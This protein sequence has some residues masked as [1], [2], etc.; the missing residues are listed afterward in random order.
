MTFI[1]RALPAIII[2][3]L[4]VVV[5]VGAS[6]P[7]WRTAVRVTL[8]A[9]GTDVPDGFLSALS[10]PSAGDCAAA[11]SFDATDAVQGLL[12]SEVGGVWHATAATVPTN[13]ASNPATT[14]YGISCGSAG[15]CGAVG[16]YA[17][18]SG[19]VEALA[20]SEVGGVW[21]RGVEITLPA[22][23]S[24]AQ[25]AE[26]HSVACVAPG[27]CSALGSYHAAST[28]HV[29]GF[30]V[31]EVGGVW[32]RATMISLPTDANANPFV[33]ADQVACGAA[34]DCSAV[35]TYV[36]TGGVS[37]ALVA[38][39][40]GGAWRPA[41][42]EALPANANAFANA[43]FSSITCTRPGDCTAL[44]TYDDS[45]GDVEAM[46]ASEVVGAWGRAREITL[47]T[48]A[49]ANSRVLLYGFDGVACATPTS[50][51]AGGQYVDGSGDYQGFVVNETDGVWGVATRLALPS[52]ATEVGKNGGVVSLTCPSAGDCSAGAAYL[53]ASGDY[54]A[55]VASEVG[56]VWQTAQ[57]ITL[58]AGAASVGVDGGIYGVICHA[59]DCTALGSYL[60]NATTYEGFTVTAP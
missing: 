28:S 16:S 27:T 44:G 31:N 9:G 40:V 21:R 59:G 46:V 42:A 45:S 43:Q 14:L 57:K 51:S 19:N 24:A 29:E 1:R 49:A 15:N 41:V 23:A 12:L 13:A 54:Q 8:P 22:G 32:R 56:G 35:G 39:E 11:G 47:P 25:T 52:G 4:A 38:N 20:V 48:G 50:C 60:A 5:P 36:T 17:E 55:A 30:V 58:P 10:C 7:A 3:S 34:G 33:S 6:A 26:L 2:A 53:D 37:Q 18:R